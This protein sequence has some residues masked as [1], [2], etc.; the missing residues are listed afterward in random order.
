MT[1]RAKFTGI[2][3]PLLSRISRKDL[4]P[5]DAPAAVGLRPLPPCFFS[6]SSFFIALSFW[7]S[8]VK[9]RRVKFPPLL[10]TV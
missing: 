2:I 3:R 8:K 1:K 6:V 4:K 5:W 9:K 10:V 7:I